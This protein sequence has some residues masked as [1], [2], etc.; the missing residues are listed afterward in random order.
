MLEEEGLP[1]MMT[2]EGIDDNNNR[3]GAN[4]AIGEEDILAK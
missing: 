1:M 4:A 3:W 2:G